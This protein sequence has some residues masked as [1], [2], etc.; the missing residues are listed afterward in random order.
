MRSTFRAAAFAAVFALSLA[1][2]GDAPEE[3]ADTTTDGATAEESYTACMVL[4]VGGV[5]DRSFNQSA[6]EGLQA[7]AEENPAIEVSYVSSQSDSDYEPN[8]RAQAESCDAVIATGGLLQDAV[9]TVAPD[10]PDVAFAIVDG[11]ANSDN[12]YG[13]TFATQQS[14]FLGGY[15]AASLTE[16]GVIATYGGINIGAPVT[17]YMDGYRQGA[18]YYNAQKGTA[19][20]VLGWDGTDGT[21]AESFGDPTTGRAVTDAFVQQNADIVFPVAGGAGSG[22][23]TA[24]EASGGA[25]KVIWVDFPGCTYYPEY[26]QYI[27]TSVLKG[28][29][30]NVTAF[31]VAA[32]EGDAPTGAYEGTLENGGTEI[33]EFNEFDSVVT[34]ETK[35]ELDAIRAG[36]V[37]GS[38]E[39]APLAS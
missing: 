29:P 11:A 15:V 12:V 28:I 13:M 33:D 35:T 37:D 18:E 16:T 6:W 27:P 21:F 8:V 4:D 31:A 26:C 17:G 3:T 30:E 1:A 14:G 9:D 38:I 25:L 5:D 19:V 2:C 7:A 36:I 23:F 32:A 34:D 24:A 10:F 22:S 20:Q 39:I